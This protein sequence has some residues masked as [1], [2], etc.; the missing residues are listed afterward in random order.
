M[1][2]LLSLVLAV[3]TATLPM[4]LLLLVVW[5]LDRYER[6]PLWMVAATFSWGAVGGVL[7]AIVFSLVMDTSLSLVLD[8]KMQEAAGPVIVAPFVEELTK[9]CILLL[10]LRHRLF[11][12]ATD[13]FVYGA[14]TGL[15]FGMTENFIYFSM[16]AMGG[17]LKSF[18]EVVYLRT[19]FS[20]PLHA[21]ASG[22]FGAALGLAK[23]RRFLPA[24]LAIP[25][26]GLGAGMALH[27]AWNALAVTAEMTQN[28]VP[29]AVAFVGLPVVMLALFGLFQLSM[30]HEKSIL[31]HELA[32][33]ARTGLL[34]PSYVPILGSWLKRTRHGWLPPSIPHHHF[35]ALCTRLAFRKY[36]G[37]RVSKAKRYEYDEEVK[38]LRQELRA[39]LERASEV[40]KG[41]GLS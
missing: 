17:D 2:Q 19:L 38:V 36:Q 31:R 16:S 11:D 9:G 34:P 8:G 4:I 26:V 18:M 27:F 1:V 20:A 40:E 22:M 25:F 10:L 12:N 30:L 39:L 13:G 7:L 6:E 15:G 37:A 33:E 32:D 24:K 5:W 28:G 35:V 3:F 21:A 14:A 29:I 23:Y 41:E